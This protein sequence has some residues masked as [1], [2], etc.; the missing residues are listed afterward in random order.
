MN[1]ALFHGEKKTNSNIQLPPGFRFHPTDEELIV[2]YLRNKATASSLP[3]AIIAEVD[4]YKCNPWELPRKALFG[5][6]ER[7]FFTPRDKKYPNGVRPNKMAA[8]G[9][10]KATGTDKPIR[11]SCGARMIGVKKALMFYRGHPP[12]GI[13]MDWNMQEYRLPKAMI[14]GGGAAVVVGSGDGGSEGDGSGGS[15]VPSKNNIRNSFEDQFGYRNEPLCEEP[16]STSTNTKLEMVRE[17]LYRDCLVLP[18]IIGSSMETVSSIS[19]EASKTSTSIC[20]GYSDTNYSQYS[21]LPSNSSIN[22]HKRKQPLKELRMRISS[23]LRRS[24]STKQEWLVKNIKGKQNPVNG[25]K[26]KKRN[27]K[28]VMHACPKKKLEVTSTSTYPTSSNIFYVLSACIPNKTP[29]AEMKSN[30]V[31]GCGTWEGIW[32]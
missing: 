4:L 30:V 31:F 8:S 9:Y 6:E 13:K 29:G 18:L 2:H 15:V 20:E 32:K 26:A 19:F 7:Y 11:S 23:N 25:R 28:D 5:K 21:V 14:G 16:C 22:G 3:A 17:F 12:R 27:G 10:W 1:K 24:S